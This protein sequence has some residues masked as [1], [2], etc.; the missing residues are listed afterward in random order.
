MI[1]SEPGC[2]FYFIFYFLYLLSS[3]QNCT[4]NTFVFDGDGDGGYRGQIQLHLLSTELFMLEQG[5]RKGLWLTFPG[6][7]RWLGKAVVVFL[8]LPQKRHIGTF[9]QRHGGD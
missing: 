8:T 6:T 9:N 7:G 4:S 1:H 3:D 5:P 2:L